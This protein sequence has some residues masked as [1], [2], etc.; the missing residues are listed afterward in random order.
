MDNWKL[1]IA[2][3][4]WSLRA[5]GAKTATVLPTE[6]RIAGEQALE[7]FTNIGLSIDEASLNFAGQAIGLPKMAVRR[8]ATRPDIEQVRGVAQR[9]VDKCRGFGLEIETAVLDFA[10]QKLNILTGAPV[11]AGSHGVSD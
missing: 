11:H 9:L 4:Q 10:G 3:A 2:G 6:V 1:Q 8:G 7:E 5:A